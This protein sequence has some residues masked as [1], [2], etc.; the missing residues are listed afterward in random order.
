M[1]VEAI[2]SQMTLKEKIGQMFLQYF[3]GYEDMPEKFKEMN[4]KNQLGGFIFFS[5]NNV[6]TIDQLHEMTQKI[7][8]QACEN[9]YNLPFLLTIDQ[10]GGQLT[11]LF[12][13][14]TIF[15]GNMTLGFANSEELA[16]EQGRHVGK[17]LKYAGINVCYA[18]VLDVDYDVHSGVPMVDNRRF[19]TK[20]E[21]VADMGTAFIKGLQD[22]HI[23]ACGKHFP[24]M[25]ITEVDTHFQVDRSPY[26]MTRLENVE[27]LPFKKAI[28][29]GLSCI[30]THHGIFDAFDTE[31]PA[32]LS[33]TVMDYLRKDLGFQGLIVTDDLI[34]KAVLNQYGEKEPIKMAIQAGADLIISTCADDWFVDYVA[35]CVENGE[36]DAQRIEESVRRILVYK[37][38]MVKQQEKEKLALNFSSGS[39]AA[40]VAKPYDQSAGNALSEKIATK[41]LI[42]Y[43]GDA[44]KL[45]VDLKTSQK[46]GIVF[47]NPARLVMSDATNLYD[48]SI[49]ETFQKELGH[50][51]IK[52]AIMPWHPTDEEIISLADVGIISDVIL[53]TTVNAYKFTRQIEV[54]KEIRRYCPNKI[55]VSVAS[56][57]PMDAEILEAYSDY[58]VVTGG[59][60]ESIFKALAHTIFGETPFECNP[61][62]D[63]DFIKGVVKS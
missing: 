23:L 46:L 37:E 32:S 7:Q 9:K 4:R 60:T 43:K 44:T 52:E 8:A 11:A 54:L 47:G 51:N 29:E 27:I 25:R 31:N 5:G 28:D 34:M 16:Y 49:K 14:T 45:P 50:M 24:G 55:I 13:G 48:L 21:V 61:A 1:N 57:S 35:E 59:L 26:D 10:E 2:L 3:Q 19:S 12:N 58:V 36:I 56:R 39:Q 30:M 33:K 62:K 15:P 40:I 22:E 6:R 20:P 17:E 63:L 53:F 38:K 41:G 42:L 18:P